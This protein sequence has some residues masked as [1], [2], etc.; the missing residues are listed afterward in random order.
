MIFDFATITPRHTSTR[1]EVPDGT[2]RVVLFFY[3]PSV[4]VFAHPCPRAHPRDDAP[5]LSGHHPVRRD[6]DARSSEKMPET[7]SRAK[8][9]EDASD[10]R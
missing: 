7:I 2:H 6:V 1:T 4:V 8:T 3:P 10:R 9:R 5:R